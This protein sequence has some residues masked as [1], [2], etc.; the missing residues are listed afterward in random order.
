VV[1]LED[2][3]GSAAHA[4]AAPAEDDGIKPPGQ[5]PLDQYL[6]LATVEKPA[7]QI[8]HEFEEPST[9]LQTKQRSRC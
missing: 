4:I 6:S 2:L 7:D 1:E 3:D 8:A 5:D 9:H